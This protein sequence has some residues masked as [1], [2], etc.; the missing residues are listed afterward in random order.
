MRAPDYI[1]NDEEIDIVGINNLAQWLIS[2][3]SDN[4]IDEVRNDHARLHHLNI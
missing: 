1:S 3:K 2:R 4:V